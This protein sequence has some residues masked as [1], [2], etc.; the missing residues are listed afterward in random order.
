MKQNSLQ[1][2]DKVSLSVI[3]ILSIVIVILLG[4]GKICENNNCFFHTGPTVKKFSWQDKEISARDTAFVITFDRPMDRA[5]V[6]KNLVID[7]PLPGKISWAGRRLAYT[8]DNPAPYGLKYQVSLE[9]ATGNYQVAEE[10]EPF[11][12]KFKTRDRAFAYIGSE[13][14][15]QGR[16]ILY[17]FTNKTKTL[18]TPQ[19]LTVFDFIPYFDS[20]RI[21]FSAA[22]RSSGVDGLQK[23]KLYSVNIELDPKS[24]NRQLKLILNNKKYQNNDFQ[25]SENGKIIVVQR[26]ERR[27]PEKFDLWLIEKERKPQ[28]LKV[29]GGE[30]LIAPDSQTLAIAKGEGIALLPLKPDSEPLD[31]LPK[32]GRILGFSRDGRAAVMVNFNTENANLRYTRSLFYVNNQGLQ[33]ELLNTSGSIIDCKFNPTATHLYCLLTEVKDAEEYQELPYLAKIDLKTKEITPILGWPEYQ[34]IQISIA[35]DGLGILFDQ[36]IT[37]EDSDRELINNSGAAIVGGNIWLLIQSVDLSSNLK[38]QL[39]QLP[40]VGVRPQWLP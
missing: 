11:V 39:E 10:I 19:E 38:P 20:D 1:P 40:L 28:P 34:D 27:N 36:L 31:F 33:K 3:F 6:E 22:D 32:F 23:L 14:K 7:P 15:E 16:L 4:S 26:M 37:T 13:G 29:Q 12:G 18:L 30:F 9:G 5:S 8:L 21:L 35:P 17:N 2:I 24:N 25:L